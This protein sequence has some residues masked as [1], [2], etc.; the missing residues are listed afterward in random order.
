MLSI[1]SHVQAHHPALASRLEQS[2][3]YGSYGASLAHGELWEEATAVFLTDHGFPAYRLNQRISDR[4]LLRT[5]QRDLAIKI[6]KTR[7]QLVEVKVL[8]PEAF[9]AWRIHIGCVEKWDSKHAYVNDRG[10]SV[11][12]PPV[13]LLILVNQGNGNAYAVEPYKGWGWSNSFYGDGQDTTV[14]RERLQPLDTY[15]GIVEGTPLAA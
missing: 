13:T 2:T 4:S 14:P 1:L 11:K 7:R 9:N 10:V 8:C 5:F 6:S 3:P 12:L 15:L